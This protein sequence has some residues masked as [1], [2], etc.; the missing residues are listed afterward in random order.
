MRSR[1]SA[2]VVGDAQYLLDSWHPSTR[3]AS[4]ELDPAQ[5]WFGLHILST[6]SGGMLDTTGTV[7]FRAKF[8]L[9]GHVG[10]QHETSRFVRSASRWV[11]LDG[12]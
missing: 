1:Y 6:S 9:D 3:P 4:L 7:E 12:A 11:Y 10:E 8:R 5:R 2:Y